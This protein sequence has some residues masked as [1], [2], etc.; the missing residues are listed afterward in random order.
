MLH[1]FRR[2]WDWL[3]LDLVIPAGLGI[4]DRLSDSA[5][6]PWQ[7]WARPYDPQPFP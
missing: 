4:L 7:R 1:R 3:V 2:A 5:G 6:A